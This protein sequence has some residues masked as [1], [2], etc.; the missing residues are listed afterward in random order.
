ME[1]YGQLIA[2]RAA[3]LHQVSVNLPWL[4]KLHLVSKIN[5]RFWYFKYIA[6][7]VFTLF[8]IVVN[9]LGMPQEDYW[10]PDAYTFSAYL[11]HF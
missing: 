7:S 2:S 6:I 5:W 11:K 10:A 9:I 3:Q 1:C 8:H 4:F